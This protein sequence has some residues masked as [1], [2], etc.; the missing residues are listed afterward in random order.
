MGEDAVSRIRSEAST[1]FKIKLCDIQQIKKAKSSVYELRDFV[2]FQRPKSS[3][4][5]SFG[6]YTTYT[7]RGLRNW[8][9]YD[10]FKKVAIHVK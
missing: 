6:R 7:K 3:L 2:A 1:I 4:R 10:D 9:L 8:E 5:N